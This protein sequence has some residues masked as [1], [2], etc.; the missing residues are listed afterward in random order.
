M[1]IDAKELLSLVGQPMSNM[2]NSG[3]EIPAFRGRI[4]ANSAQSVI[5]APTSEPSFY[6]SCVGPDREKM[7]TSIDVIRHLLATRIYNFGPHTPKNVPEGV[8]AGDWV[9]VHAAGSGVVAYFMATSCIHPTVSPP[10]SNWPLLVS[11]DK[12]VYMDEPVR[13]CA[14]WSKLDWQRAHHLPPG[15]WGNFVRQSTWITRHDFLVLT[16]Q[17]D[18]P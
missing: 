4:D 11:I 10:Q 5:S 13:A 15:A 2:M 6:I 3:K 16:D 1:P 9:C 12:R 18:E 14:V 8:G 7:W 17:L